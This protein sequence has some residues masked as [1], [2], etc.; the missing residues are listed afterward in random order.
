MTINI[1]L[2]VTLFILN[3]IY[4][5]SNFIIKSNK[6]H[7]E[8]YEFSNAL[9]LYILNGLFIY[10]SLKLTGYI[11]YYR[12]VIIL[13]FILMYILLVIS[14]SFVASVYSK[15]LKKDKFKY[16]KPFILISHY[17]LYPIGNLYAKRLEELDEDVLEEELEEEFLEILD[18][19]AEDGSINENENKLIRSVL[20]FDEL[21]ITD[22]FTPR[23][24]V[25]GISI[26]ESKEN[27]QKVFQS[28]G[29]SR[30]PI[31]NEDLDDI[32]G[33][34]HFKDFYNKV[35]NKKRSIKSVMTE[36]LEVTE[37]MTVTNLLSLLK[38]NKQHLAIVKDEY[39]GTVGIVTMEDILEELV[40]DIFDEHDK[41]S[42]NYTKVSD[43]RYRVNGSTYLYELEDIFNEDDLEKVDY[44][45]VNGLITTN[46]GKIGEV[47]DSFIYNNLKVTVVKADNKMVKEAIIEVL[48]IIEEKENE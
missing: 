48:D 18:E 44:S 34:I 30:L 33:I 25:I 24:D 1:I 13:S 2:V 41:V 22:I 45:T 35:L 29:F 4:T 10:Y 23:I 16:F 39:G 21:K 7:R 40:G 38:L 15:N 5:F 9:T 46:L 3:I 37:Y 8:K 17:L 14:I 32:I 11:N 26:T 43:K 27:I 20:E 6:K 42:T 36:P 19:A 28:S 12:L 47:N 31:Y